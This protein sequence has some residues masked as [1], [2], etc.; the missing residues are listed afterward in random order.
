MCVNRHHRQCAILQSHDWYPAL[1]TTRALLVL[2]PLIELVHFSPQARHPVLCYTG[3]FE[4]P[5]GRTVCEGVSDSRRDV[6]CKS[7]NQWSRRPR[8]RGVCDT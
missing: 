1:H 6:D 7:F 8:P 4:D 3:W 5:K 2:T